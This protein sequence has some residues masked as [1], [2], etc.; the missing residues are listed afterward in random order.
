MRFLLAVLALLP[1]ALANL[2]FTNP[3]LMKKEGDLSNILSYEMGSLLEVRWTQPP[4]GQQTSLGLW[5][6]NATTAEFFGSM[7]YVTRMSCS[8]PRTQTL[9]LNLCILN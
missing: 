6:L 8:V 1:S 4:V 7:E 2:E 3:P 9:S 5:Q